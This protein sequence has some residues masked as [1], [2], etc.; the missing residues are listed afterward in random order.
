MATVRVLYALTSEHLVRPTGSR[1]SF[2]DN[3]NRRMTRVPSTA[4]FSRSDKAAASTNLRLW[5]HRY[6]GR[7]R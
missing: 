6:A 1:V 5:Y 3:K 7:W 4:V 2:F